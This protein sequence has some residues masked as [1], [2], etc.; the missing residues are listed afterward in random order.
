MK[1]YLYVFAA[2]IAL[3][4]C[5][6]EDA[7]TNNENIQGLTTPSSLSGVPALN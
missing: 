4:A 5:G 6:R 7:T 3:S 2:F 1:T